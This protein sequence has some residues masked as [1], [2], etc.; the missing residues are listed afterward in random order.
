MRTSARLGIPMAVLAALMLAG[1]APEWWAVGTASDGATPSGSPSAASDAEEPDGDAA[2]ANGC[3]VGA[4]V[5]DNDSWA[6]ELARIWSEGVPGVEVSVTGSLELDWRD[7]GDYLL[8]ATA[9]RTSVSGVAEGAGFE[10]IVEH[11]GTESGAWSGAD[12]DYT[13]VATDESGM[14]SV[15]SMN[16]GGGA[17]VIDQSTISSEPWSGSMTVACTGAGMTT[18]V[19]EASGTITVAWMRR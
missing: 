15:V 6:A 5:L 10:Q 8:T 16:A 12:A 13:L 14:T 17:M 3:P 7:G 4:W 11:D 19:T 2:E 1:C 18:T 9:A